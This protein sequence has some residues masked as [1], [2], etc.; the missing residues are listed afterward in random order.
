LKNTIKKL[1]RGFTLI[2]LLV[3]I[4]IIGV[5]ATVVLVNYQGSRAKARDSKRKQDVS[6]YQ[7]AV[8]AFFDDYNVYPKAGGSSGAAILLAGCPATYPQICSGVGGNPAGT[9]YIE[10]LVEDPLVKSLNPADGEK[11]RLWRE[12]NK[13]FP[14]G[15]SVKKNIYFRYAYVGGGETGACSGDTNAFSYIISVGIENPTDSSSISDGGQNPYRYEVGGA[16]A[17][18]NLCGLCGII[19]G[20]FQGTKIINDLDCIV[21]NSGGIN[22]SPPVK[23]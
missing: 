6:T 1:S 10:Q 11:A 3:V 9:R 15:T 20:E 23:K 14:N 17:T 21:T 18:K 7:G 16:R 5:L 12:V 8:E 2:E 13:N 4:T 19:N 22:G